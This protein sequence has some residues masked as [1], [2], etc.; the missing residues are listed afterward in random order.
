MRSHRDVADVLTLTATGLSD[1]E[2]TRRTGV[3]RS[4]VHRWRTVGSPS[5]PSTPCPVCAGGD[6]PPPEAYAYLLGLYLGD[7]W[8]GAHPREVHR[9][10]IYLDA[11]YPDIVET[12]ATAME[13]VRPGQ[14]ADRH[15]HPSSNMVI[16]RMYSQHW[17]CL[18]PQHGP[19]KKHE[20]RISLVPWQTAIVDA[21]PEALLRGL[22]HSDG[23]RVMNR[24][25]TEKKTY[26]YSR[27]Q[28]SNRS[29]DIHNIFRDACDRVGV[30]WRPSGRYTTSVSRRAS[31]AK[32]DAFI[33]PK[34]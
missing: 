26:F 7:G 14:Q 15:P 20:R 30:D 3:P 33:G 18:F 27:Y 32:L 9:L 2:V 24:A 22:I 16:V 21:E 19:G 29:Q 13:S 34:A 12:C 4:T 23:C 5:S 17:P 25:S 28:F 10:N 1:H 11:S 6:P 8:I 31:V